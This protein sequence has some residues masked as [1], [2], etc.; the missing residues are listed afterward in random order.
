MSTSLFD[1]FKFSKQ[2]DVSD[3]KLSLM[4]TPINIIPTSILCNQQKMLIASLGLEKAYAAIYSESK[5]G[6]YEYNS[7]FIKKYG[8]SDKHKIIEWQIKIVAFAGWGLLE[9]ALLDVNN[10]SGIVHFK[11]SPYTE[12][13]GRSDYPIDFTATGFVAGGLSVVLGKDVDAVET[14]CQALGDRFCVIEV[15]MPD[16]IE[17]KRVE[18]WK[19]YKLI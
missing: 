17:K 3:G 19:N 6:S 14:K 16:L 10:N 12:Y 8:F 5:K 9:V 11:N 4:D 7:A 15:G 1:L 2:L 18:L 13:Y